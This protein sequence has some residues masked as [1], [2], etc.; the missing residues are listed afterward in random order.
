MSIAQSI[1]AKL[2][3]KLATFKWFERTISLICVSIP[4]IL[5]FADHGC[6]FCFRTSISDYVYMDHN[7]AFGLLLGIAA[8][9]FI[10]NGAVYF[11]NE[12]IEK[13]NLNKQGKWYNIVLGLS[14][15]GVIIFPWREFTIPHYAFAGIFFGGN[16]VVTGLFHDKKDRA[17][18]IAMAIMTVAALII[19]FINL[20]PGF[21][22]LEAEWVSLAVIGI[23]FF[24]QSS[25]KGLV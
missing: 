22:T 21:T 24:L 20:I 25:R 17:L 6:F 3:D 19:R 15:I 2:H 13:L 11:K 4:L 9:L 8:M 23:H 7:Y 1:K 14:L 16:A 5:M 18:S 12:A 10:F